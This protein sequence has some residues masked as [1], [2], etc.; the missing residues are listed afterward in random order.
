MQ[1]K[2]AQESQMAKNLETLR[3]L[4]D[5]YSSDYEDV[6]NQTDQWQQKAEDLS[7]ELAKTKQ[8]LA[9]M[10]RQRE[11][12]VMR[13]KEARSQEDEYF[14]ENSRLEQQDEALNTKLNEVSATAN[15][16]LKENKI[17]KQKVEDLK[18][19][20]N[21]EKANSHAAWVENEGQLMQARRDLK[22]SERA[23]SQMEA[24][25]QRTEAILTDKERQ[26]LGLPVLNKTDGKSQADA[27][28]AVAAPSAK[29]VTQPP[30]VAV[31]QAPVVAVTQ[32][33][34]PETPKANTAVVPL[35]EKT[36]KGSNAE[37]LTP[38]V[39]HVKVWES[40]AKPAKKLLAKHS[41]PT[42]VKPTIAVTAAVSTK[43]DVTQAPLPGEP[44]KPVDDAAATLASVSD[45]KPT[46]G[47]RSALQKLA[48]FFA[49]PLQR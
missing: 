31:T 13:A 8:Q 4:K 37:P 47:R 2:D 33:P 49:S 45:A 6:K 35:A 48:D 10:T 39:G 46:S 7:G 34:A 44:P 26:T 16:S 32:A 14:E 3:S 21:Q 42:E 15:A 25:L 17:L 9:S 19:E 30:T 40:A 22:L 18:D 41:H 1:R 29:A 20:E 28:S 36:E 43:T 27:K 5:H 11:K 38:Q 23:R 12:A 24:E